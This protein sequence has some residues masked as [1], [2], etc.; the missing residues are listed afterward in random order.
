MKLRPLPP[1]STGPR[2][3]TPIPVAKK[4][5]RVC[6]SCER[7]KPHDGDHFYRSAHHKSGLSPVCKEC[8]K[9]RVRASKERRKARDAE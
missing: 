8:A 5:E 1:P 9:E 4:G 2:T 6:P 3:F 7:V